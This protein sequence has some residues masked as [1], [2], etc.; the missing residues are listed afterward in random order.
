MSE[1][2]KTMFHTDSNQ[3][4]TEEQLT[5]L[6]KVLKKLQNFSLNLFA[7]EEV[8]SQHLTD[9]PWNTICEEPRY[10]EFLLENFE[11]DVY[12]TRKQVMDDFNRFLQ[13]VSN[14]CSIVKENFPEAS[15]HSQQGSL[16]IVYETIK[17]MYI[18]KLEKALLTNDEFQYQKLS[19]AINDCKRII[20]EMPRDYEEQFRIDPTMN[21]DNHNIPSKML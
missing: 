13:N 18:P 9:I 17:Q 19:K 7:N 3:P 21:H 2:Y 11:S 8:F 15:P 6:H 14:A 16:P 5:R 12:T 20:K 4:L 1:E 10:T